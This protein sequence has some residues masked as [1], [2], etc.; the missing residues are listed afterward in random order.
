M[1]METYRRPLE[2]GF[3]ERMNEEEV[4]MMSLGADLEQINWHR[5]ILGSKCDGSYDKWHQ[6]Y[7]TEPDDAFL[8]TGIKIFP[9]DGLKRQEGAVLDPR[10]GSLTIIIPDKV[11]EFNPM[12]FGDLWVLE[13]PKEGFCYANGNDVA[14]NRII[15]E[16]ETDKSVSVMIRRGPLDSYWSNVYERTKGAPESGDYMG[17]FKRPAVVAM[18]RGK[19]DTDE[20]AVLIENFCRWYNGAWTNVENNAVGTGVIDILKRSYPRILQEYSFRQQGKKATQNLGFRTLGGKSGS[21]SVLIGSLVTAV[22]GEVDRISGLRGDQLLDVFFQQIIDEYWT[23]AAK[24]GRMEA[25]TGKFDDIVIASA[26]A[27]FTHLEAPMSRPFNTGKRK[28]VKY[29][30]RCKVTGY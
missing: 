17:D 13:E 18:W 4:R 3:N 30:P 26:L 11:Y 7:P 28:K 19:I 23:F 21:K 20:F 25:E 16:R 1:D 14:E 5:W 10:R 22:C 29:Q 15:V 8:A 6:E 24:D 12:D 9:V 2:P 27:W